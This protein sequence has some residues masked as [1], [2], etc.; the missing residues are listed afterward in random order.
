[1]KGK[2]MAVDFHAHWFPPQLVK[3]FDRV[4][5]KPVWPEHPSTI[6][7]RVAELEEDNVGLQIIGLGHNQPYVEDADAA[8]QCTKFANDLYADAVGVGGGRLAVFGAIPLP[9]PEPAAAEAIRCLDEL[10]FAGIGLGTTAL[11][12]SLDDPAFEEVWSE[13]DLRSAVVFVHPV[14][15]PETVSA[16][17]GEFMMG[18]KYGGPQEIT[19]SA[20][21]LAVS[22]VPQRHPN[23]KWVM[24]AMGG[25][26]PYLWRRFEEITQCLEQDDWL[27]NDPAQQLGRYY[28]DTALSDDPRVIQFFLDTI[29]VERLVLGTDAPRVRTGDWIARVN[30]VPGLT[31]DALEAVMSGNAASLGLGHS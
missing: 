17:L 28:Y 27:A 24:A 7:G 30:K 15:T 6:E 31:G 5:N 16:G 13:L 14:G 26:L 21:R 23:I 1:M 25:S 29:G 11:G 20:T 18:P 12:Q 10:G 4:A 8:R 9:H 22:G 2:I 3:E 19:I